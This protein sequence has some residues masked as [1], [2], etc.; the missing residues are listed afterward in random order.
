MTN[1]DNRSK[2]AAD[3]PS[4][5]SGQDLRQKAEA[6]ARERAARTPEDGKA[7]SPEEIRK[8][9]HELR[10]H[11]IELEMQNE[12]LRTGQVEI[13]AGR[14]RY[15]DLYDLAP[16]G[17][18]TLSEHGVILEANLTA[19][20]LLGTTRGLLVKQPFS[21]FI[22][23]EDQD[24]YYL[25]RKILSETGEPREC[26]LRLVKPDGALIWA[27][28]TATAAQAEDGAPVCLCV[29]SDITEC[30]IAEDALQ[31]SERFSRNLIKS[32]G[33]GFSILD[34]KGVHIDVNPAFC[35]MTGFTPEELIGS[36]PPHPYWPEEEYGR[37]QIVFSRMMKEDFVNSELIF[38]RKNGERFPV[39]VTPS[40]VED[41]RE[42]V[43][44]YFATVKDITER[45]QAEEA[46]RESEARFRHLLQS[47]PNISVQGYGPDGTTRYWNEASEHLYGYTAQEAIGRNL[48]DLIIPTEMRGEVEQAMQQMAETG[49]QIPASEMSLMRKDG[50]RVSVFSS[51]ATLQIPGQAPEL[52]CMDIDITERK[53]AEDKLRDS[54]LFFHTTINSLKGHICVLDETG[55]IVLTNQAWDDFAIAN[56][57]DPQCVSEGVNYLSVCD[58]VTGPDLEMAGSCSR[59]IRAVLSGDSPQFSMEYPCHSPTEKRWFL[60]NV[61]PLQKKDSRWAVISHENITERKQAEEKMAEHLHELQRWYDVMLDREGRVIKL[62]RE[63]NELLV[64]AGEPPR[65]SS[66][67]AGG[68]DGMPGDSPPL[69]D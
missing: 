68:P 50:S 8:T 39:I 48:I 4:A 30:K 42:G 16:V 63:V 53:R 57:A 43:I 2:D 11:Q 12:E 20:A 56:S 17:Y 35:R 36:G 18:C 51:H 23:K 44:R 64:R 45:K 54:E 49:Q 25:H 55:K 26:E 15:Y 34:E 52:F 62:K 28:L 58:S 61:S 21:R 13:E 29:I 6:L 41:A 14:D 32:M 69:K 3:D 22:F 5:G 67:A 38:K 10:V 33:D 31:E 27:H 59:G 47:V 9:I 46:L 66:A 1:Q 19:A 60:G 40:K 65:Y 7:L 24:S 37:I